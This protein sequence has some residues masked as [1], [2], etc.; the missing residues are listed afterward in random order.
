M[1]VLDVVA[2]IL[3]VMRSDLQPDIRNH[4][5][6]EIHDQYLDAS[7]A[8]RVLGWAPAFEM[9]ASL[10]ATVEWYREYFARG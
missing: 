7:K 9:E 1:S 8:K 6:H 10:R 2:A 4:A 5:T 3:G